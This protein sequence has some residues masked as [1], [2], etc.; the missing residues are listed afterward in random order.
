L[1]HK[2]I[3]AYNSTL[4]VDATGAATIPTTL[5]PI[6]TVLESRIVQLGLRVDW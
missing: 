5:V 6:S 4:T 3:T 1:N 2:N